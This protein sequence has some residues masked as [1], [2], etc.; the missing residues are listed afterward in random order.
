M[1]SNWQETAR[2]NLDQVMSRLEAGE[3]NNEE[4]GVINA[5][6]RI[7][8]P[9]ADFV[10]E[11]AVGPAYANNDTPMTSD[12]KFHIASVA[13]PMTATLILQLFEEG[14][15]GPKGL[16]SN[17]AEL[18]VFDEDIVKRLHMIDG[19]SYGKQMTIR[20]LL[21]HTSGIKEAVGDD[22][23]GTSKDYGHPAPES[24]GARYRAGFE[25]HLAC[26]EDPD[27]NLDELVTSKNW[28]M[29]DPSRPDDKE[30]G[31]VNWFLA[32][33]TSAAALWPPGEQF[34][35][36]DTG[37]VILGLVAEKL[38]GKSLHR[39]WRERIFDPLG[40]DK[41][42]LAYAK[43]PVPDEWVHDV[44]D[45][46]VGAIGGVTSK[47]NISFDRGGGGVVST[48]GDL[49]KYIQGLIQGNLFKK[50]ETLVNMTQ[51]R[52][53]PGINTPRAGVGLGI[54]AEGTESGTV[55]IG[56]SGAY[57]T[58]M[59]YEPETGIYFSGTVN[60]RTGVPYYWWHHVIRAI[61][62]AGIR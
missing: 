42:Y 29:W 35:Y 40:M 55:L 25:A 18:G 59:Y 58:K 41:S 12:H 15:L 30:A 34:Y 45:F 1:K 27:C 10:Y 14:A 62:D 39:Q 23:G 43:D 32:T 50:T 16:D 28:E 44:S 46:F 3:Y 31:V 26:L 33:G 4:I 11:K 51:W 61:H 17:L 24:Y 36:S 48:V 9:H 49:N 6:I 5:V 47:F 54:F 8:I 2:Q 52:Y 21:M 7:D 19:K 37:Y 20:H 22:T 60:Q 57:G 38:S 13:K 53:L 56:H